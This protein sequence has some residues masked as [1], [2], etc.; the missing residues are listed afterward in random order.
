M[1]HTTGETWI[2]PTEEEFPEERVLSREE[3]SISRSNIPENVLK[4]LYRLHR[5]G[6]KG[7][8]CGGS[9]RDLLLGRQPKDFDVV[10]DARPQEIRRL[11]RNSRIIGRRFRLAHIMF[12]DLVVE[13]STFRREPDLQNSETDGDLLVRD[14][15]VFGTPIQDARRRDFTVN[16]LFYDIGTFSVIDYVGGIDDLR[17]GVIRV[18][19]DPD[20][21]FREDPVRMMRALEF[22]AR[23]DFEVE[24]GTWDAIR[25]HRE[26]ILKASPARVTDEIL[27]LL[28]RGWSLESMHLMEETSLLSPLL[29]ELG[30]LIDSGDGDYLWK[31]LGVLDRTIKSRREISDIVL[32]SVLLLPLIME[33]IERREGVEGERIQSGEIVPFIREQIDAVFERLVMPAWMRHEIV[34]N[35]ELLWRMQEPPSERKRDWRLVLRERFHDALALY[36]LYSFSSGRF[37]ESFRQWRDLAGR[38]RG[39]QPQKAKRR[40][41]RRSKQ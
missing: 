33:A 16:G 11:F 21:R 6:R 25:R 39:D 24:A 36:E 35:F 20:L 29:P 32:L 7:Y 38:V 23:L 12:Q 13:V 15:N 37:V 8:L 19:G 10:T 14:D 5:S 41:R 2:A 1:N 27:E 30:A 31:M 3:H 34:Q 40:R 17:A 4:V 28:R 18:I 26:D 22:A 9:V